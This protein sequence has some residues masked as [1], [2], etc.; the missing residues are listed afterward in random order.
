MPFEKINGEI[1]INPTNFRNLPAIP[2]KDY[3]LYRVKQSYFDAEGNEVQ[4]QTKSSI[5]KDFNREEETFGVKDKIKIYDLMGENKNVCWDLIT[6][7]FYLNDETGVDKSAV[8]R[9]SFIGKCFVKWKHCL[10]AEAKN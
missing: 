8:K 5:F 1:Q 7:E 10:D 4:R 2:G 6:I 3:L 9:P